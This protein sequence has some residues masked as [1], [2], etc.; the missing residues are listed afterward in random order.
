[1]FSNNREKKFIY[2]LNDENINE[3]KLFEDKLHFFEK[4]PENIYQENNSKNNL[5]NGK[6]LNADLKEEE[7]DY[8]ASVYNIPLSKDINFMNEI[9]TDNELIS[10]SMNF[11]EKLYFSE[12]DKSNTNSV[13]FNENIFSFLN[14]EEE[15]IN[16]D[17]NNLINNIQLFIQMNKRRKKNYMIDLQ[18]NN[19]FFNSIDNCSTKASNHIISR[20]SKEFRK[21]LKQNE[22]STI[23]ALH[24]R[25]ASQPFNGH[26]LRKNKINKNSNY[27]IN[28]ND[29]NNNFKDFKNKNKNN[30]L[31]HY[32]NDENIKMKSMNRVLDLTNLYEE[33][34]MNGNSLINLK[35]LN[36]DKNRRI[37]TNEYARFE[38]E[39]AFDSSG[40]QKFLCV[41]RLGEENKNMI[42]SSKSINNKKNNNLKEI[43][44]RSININNPNKILRKHRIKKNNSNIIEKFVF[45]S[46]QISYKNIFSPNNKNCF[47]RLYKKNSV[48][49]NGNQHYTCLMKEKMNKSNN[50]IGLN[51]KLKNSKSFIFKYWQNKM[52]NKMNN[53]NIK[54]NNIENN[55]Y[56][57]QFLNSFNRIINSE[58]NI[59]KNKESNIT[60]DKLN[61]N[62]N[63]GNNHTLNNNSRNYN[64]YINSINSRSA[65]KNVHGFNSLQNN[66]DNNYI[67]DNDNLYNSIKNSN[68][69]LYMSNND[70]N[71]KIYLPLSNFDNVKIDYSIKNNI[72][73]HE[74]KV[75]KEKSNKKIN[76]HFKNNS[77]TMID[78]NKIINL[79]SLD[80]SKIHKKY[81]NLYKIMKDNARDKK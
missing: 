72:K 19:Y 6:S 73:F 4:N 11:N 70:N 24:L 31:Q 76:R 30:I 64:S 13:K 10:K 34:K 46:P 32:T 14:K 35:Y 66:N 23:P 79:T 45:Y 1:M 54:N 36:K 67:M 25:L 21:K 16:E 55:S 59:D 42:I 48:K 7:D 62:I 49:M 38:E 81:N 15:N 77:K 68:E 51:N 69:L 63:G 41:K 26:N 33:N 5:I 50:K 61:V 75:S 60:N 74:I 39:Y 17:I 40:N 57:V 44:I 29:E 18:Y 78:K 58:N 47:S 3:E 65:Y 20:F 8:N 43:M 37:K 56:N 28:I 9:I 22:S 27:T 53:K 2:I 71:N 12:R 52:N 80:N